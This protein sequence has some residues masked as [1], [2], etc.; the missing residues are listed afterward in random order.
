MN[1]QQRAIIKAANEYLESLLKDDSTGHD[2]LHGHRVMNT[3][4]ELA[5]GTDADPYVIALAA[6]LHD[7][8][9]KKLFKNSHHCEDFL[10]QHQV[11]QK[12]QIMNIIETMSF[13]AYEKGKNVSTIEGQ[14][15]QD[16][17]RLDALGAIGIA[18]CFAYSGYAGRPIYRGIRDDDSAISHFYQKLLRLPELMN[19]DKA[20]LKA[21]KRVAFMKEYLREFYREWEEKA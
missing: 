14:L 20:K 5:E 7:L 13:S 2:H 15:V 3:A 4:L 10:D 12:D 6:L 21:T 11:K 16:A 17:D 18:R 1:D 8:D 9:D 19:T